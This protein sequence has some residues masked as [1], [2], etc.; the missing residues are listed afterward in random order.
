MGVGY[1]GLVVTLLLFSLCSV[2]MLPLW[3]VKDL[4]IKENR[5]VWL[6]PYTPCTSWTS[7]QNI[8]F[9]LRTF[10]Y[11]RSFKRSLNEV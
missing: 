3:T 4:I 2:D 6:Q 10:S 9:F 7:R 1:V 11:P 8:A 5:Q